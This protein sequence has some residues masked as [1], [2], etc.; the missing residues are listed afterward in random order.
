MTTRTLS[1]IV[2]GDGFHW[3]G[4]GFYVTQLLPGNPSLQEIADPFLLMDYHPV[5]E[6]PPTDRPRGVGAHPHRGF[7]TVTLAFEGAVQ[8]HD[9]TG[10]GGI[11]FPGDA[12]WMTAAKGIL[13]KEY[14]EV[15]WAKQGGRFHMMQLWVNL[16]SY[17]KMNEPRYQALTAEQMGKVKLNGGGTVTL[18][19]GELDGEKGPALTHTPIELWDVQLS[20]NESTELAVPDGHTMMV[21]V[22]DGSIE[23]EGGTIGHEQ[24]GIFERSG[25]QLTLTA[26]ETGARAIVLGG[27]P[28]GE[29]VIFYGPF[30]M[31]T[32]REIVQAIQD[33]NAGTFGHLV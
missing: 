9:S 17:D 4:D 5:K 29:P 16:P 19:S 3:V 8:H 30:A 28:I 1:Q 25:D 23:T 6:Y 13:H 10:G 14:H 32:E 27:E 18:Y 15:E 2:S 26:P 21:F 33:F 24:L 12:Q 7:E 22:L 11:I 20:A 31:N